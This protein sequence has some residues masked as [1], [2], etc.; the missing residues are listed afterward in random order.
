MT[1]MEKF[2][3]TIRYTLDRTSGEPVFATF[4]FTGRQLQP[5]AQQR[6]LTYLVGRP[7]SNVDLRIVEGLAGSEGLECFADIAAVVCQYQDPFVRGSE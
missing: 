4:E 1:L 6:L 3:D 5:E 7:L 2:G